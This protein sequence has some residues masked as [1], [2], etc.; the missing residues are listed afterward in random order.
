MVRVLEPVLPD[1]PPLSSLPQAATPNDKPATRQLDA[2]SARTRK[3]GPSSETLFGAGILPF[4]PARSQRPGEPPCVKPAVKVTPDRLLGHIAHDDPRGRGDQRRSRRVIRNASI[5]LL[6][7]AHRTIQ[8]TRPMVVATASPMRRG[9]SSEGA[10]AK[11]AT[12]SRTAAAGSSAS[13]AARTSR[14]PTMTPSAPALGRG[15]RRAPASRCRSRARRAPRSPPG[16]ARRPRR[17][18]PPSPPRSPVVPVT[19]TV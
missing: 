2:A 18:R 4:V 14:L 15:A 9:R 5:A 17:G 7:S 3:A 1:P 12:S 13:A 10:C 16:R 6:P 8:I 11:P 19:D